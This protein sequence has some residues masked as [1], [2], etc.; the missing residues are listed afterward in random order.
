MAAAAAKAELSA[1]GRLEMPRI[2]G[3]VEGG[4]GTKE[5]KES[6]IKGV[7]WLGCGWRL[8]GRLSELAPGVNERRRASGKQADGLIWIGRGEEQNQRQRQRL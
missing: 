5:R 8:H 2:Q 7:E 4:K 1:M 3:R 6:R